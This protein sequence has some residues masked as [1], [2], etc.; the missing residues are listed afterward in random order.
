M[1]SD[2]NCLEKA[3]HSIRV[4]VFIAKETNSKDISQFRNTALLNVEGKIFFSVL[5]RR[6]TNYLLK[7][8]YVETNCQKAGVPGF[9]GYIELSTMVWDQIQKAKQEKICMSSGLTLPMRMDQF[10]IS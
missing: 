8:G 9:P 1:V 6:M 3:N 5:A 10:L 4:F 7:N 2:E